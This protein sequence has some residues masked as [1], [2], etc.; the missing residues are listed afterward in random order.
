[1]T[2]PAVR[3][4][5]YR[6]VRRARTSRGGAPRTAWR[7]PALLGAVLMTGI[8]LTACGSA[9]QAGVAGPQTVSVFKLRP[10]QCVV[11][12]KSN[13]NLQVSTIT[14]VPCTQSHTEEVYCVLPYTPSPPSGI[15]RCPARPTRLS[16]NLTEDYP[17][18]KALETFANAMCLDEFQPYVGVPY[19]DSSLYYSYLYPSPRSW[20]DVTRRD[21][22]VACVLVTTGAPLARSAKGSRL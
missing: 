11:P 22:M 21:R 5:L 14:V 20:D 1:M 16:G 12:P 9:S 3:A 10:G 2:L 7:G 17:G 4:H 19:K 18:D 6:P 8:L 13:P 15:P